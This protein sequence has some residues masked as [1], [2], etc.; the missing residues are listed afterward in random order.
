MGGDLLNLFPIGD[1]HLGLYLLDVSG[2]GVPA[3][4]LAVA[5]GHALNPHGDPSGLRRPADVVRR[6]NERLCEMARVHCGGRLVSTLEGG[7]DLVALAE[8]S[9]AH[10]AAMLAA[11]V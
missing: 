5:V 10:V 3:S 2:H 7:Y 1:G 8:S 11:K 6:V 4:L 9:D